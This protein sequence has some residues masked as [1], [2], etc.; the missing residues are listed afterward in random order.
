LQKVQF[1]LHPYNAVYPE[2]VG[3]TIEYNLIVY[4]L[5]NIFLSFKE[6]KYFIFTS[7]AVRSYSIKK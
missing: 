5:K 3:Y 2:N 6:E 7:T 1:L 4:V